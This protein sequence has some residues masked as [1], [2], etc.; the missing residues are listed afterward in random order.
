MR[1]IQ[2]M[3]VRKV[4]DNEIAYSKSTEQKLRDLELENEALK[5]L[6]RVLTEN[7]K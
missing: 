2:Q 5:A 4:K 7:K 1:K 3:G 6:V